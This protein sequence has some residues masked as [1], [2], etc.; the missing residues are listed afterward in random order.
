MCAPGVRRFISW[1]PG[2]ALEAISA[3]SRLVEPPTQLFTSRPPYERRNPV[4]GTRT[5]S[6]LTGVPCGALGGSGRGYGRGCGGPRGGR[7]APSGEGRGR[8]GAK[9][10]GPGNPHHAQWALQGLDGWEMARTVVGA[11]GRRVPPD[12]VGSSV[13]TVVG[14]CRDVS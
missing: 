10:E 8:G 13:G 2:W 7:L 1:C 9:C 14:S 11:E 12:T 6:Y 4:I 5:R 3:Q